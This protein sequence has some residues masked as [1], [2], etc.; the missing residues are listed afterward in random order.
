MKRRITLVLV[1]LLALSLISCSLLGRFAGKARETAEAA[2]ISAAVVIASLPAATTAAQSPGIEP[3]QDGIRAGGPGGPIQMDG[4][5]TLD[6]YRAD[7]L[8]R[9]TVP[10][11]DGGTVELSY[12][13]EWTRDPPAQHIWMETAHAPFVE[14]IWADGQ[15]WVKQGSH[16]VQ[17]SADEAVQPVKDFHEAFEI[18]DE[19]TLVGTETIHGVR[20][21]H[22][23]S[24]LTS[25]NGQFKMLRE[26][27]M[28][29]QPG[30]PK[31]GVRAAFRMESQQ[32]QGVAAS[33]TEATLYD[34]NAPVD[35]E[36]PQ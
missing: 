27:W 29:N 20:A 4:L 11:S 7:W 19:M 26:M 31:V 34:I 21:D 2:V 30:L 8:T 12:K 6:S 1:G 15:V 36:P 3:A 5:N 17:S 23:V 24:D 14:A 18:E 10:G 33:E 25:A 28:A 9:T 13:L 32:A 22:Y 16:W 35:I